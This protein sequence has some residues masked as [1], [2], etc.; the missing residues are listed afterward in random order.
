MDPEEFVLLGVQ[1][2][3]IIHGKDVEPEKMK[4]VIQDLLP[5]SYIFPQNGDGKILNKKN[6]PAVNEKQLDSMV[7]LA[8][9]KDADVN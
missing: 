1:H 5:T 9:K 6:K 4:Q 2:Y 7:E 3:Y 8:V